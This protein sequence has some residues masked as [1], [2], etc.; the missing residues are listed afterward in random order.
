MKNRQFV[1][2]YY[3]FLLN[4]NRSLM[5]WSF[6]VYYRCDDQNNIE[7]QHMDQCLRLIEIQSGWSILI[8]ILDKYNF[9]HFSLFRAYT[10]KKVK[11][12][13]NI[14]NIDIIVHYKYMMRLNFKFFI[15]A[16][17]ISNQC[18]STKTDISENLSRTPSSK[19]R[20]IYGD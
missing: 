20:I 9:E 4:Y 6:S 2:I 5:V 19:A 3:H 15:A 11:P 10:Y 18:K 1:N 17:K 8:C 14:H 16:A 12:N 13:Q 7:N